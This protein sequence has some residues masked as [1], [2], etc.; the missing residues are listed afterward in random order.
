MKR[1]TAALYDPYLDVMGGGERHILSMLQVLEREGYD[2]RLYWGKD[3]SS[4]IKD[5]LNLSFGQLEF[6]PNI[7]AASSPLEK[8]RKMMDVDMF[9][10]VTD[11]SYFFSGA[12]KNFIFC[13][14]PDRALYRMDIANRLKTLNASF[15][16]NSNYTQSWLRR[17]NIASSVIYP[18]V[19]DDFLATLTDLSQKEKIILSVGRFFPHLHAKRHDA[20][21]QAFLKFS[22]KNSGYKLILAGGMKNEDGAYVDEIKKTTGNRPDIQLEINIPFAKLLEYYR[23]AMLFWHFTGYGVNENEHPE[24]VEHLG[25]TPLEAMA[26]GTPVF[27]YNAGGPREILKDQENG[28]LFNTQ[29]ELLQKTDRLLRDPALYKAVQNKGRQYVETNFGY[30]TFEKRVKEILLR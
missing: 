3:L 30:K 13:M 28:F 10:Y 20:I 1:K 7:F 26:A 2:I 19:A 11:G 6:A 9:F 22:E 21:I 12:K 27:C 16:A 4:Q 24:A 25:M 5:K 15:I 23:K 8:I 18:Y 29:E 14:V 17:W